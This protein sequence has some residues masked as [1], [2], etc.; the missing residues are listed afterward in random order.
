MD[1]E[2]WRRAFGVV[3]QG[4]VPPRAMRVYTFTGASRGHRLIMEEM[5]VPRPAASLSLSLPCRATKG[6]RRNRGQT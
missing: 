4:P 5:G 2:T 3:R 6:R 1:R